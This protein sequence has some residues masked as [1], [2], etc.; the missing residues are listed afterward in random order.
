MKDTDQGI[1][2]VIHTTLGIRIE[3]MLHYGYVFTTD[4]IPLVSEEVLERTITDDIRDELLTSIEFIK[5]L[6][7]EDLKRLKRSLRGKLYDTLDGLNY[8]LVDKLVDDEYGLIPPRNINKRDI[9]LFINNNKYITGVD[10]YLEYERNISWLSHMLNSTIHTY[11]TITIDDIVYSIIGNKYHVC[12]DKDTK[13]SRTL[14]LLA[15]VNYKL[16]IHNTKKKYNLAKK[17][18]AGINF[19]LNDEEIRNDKRNKR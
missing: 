1:V 14:A 6:L 10:T 3:I 18:L 9:L 15:I 16:G 17:T 8:L 13:D 4:A 2:L 7:D 11:A 12:I 5:Q 19:N